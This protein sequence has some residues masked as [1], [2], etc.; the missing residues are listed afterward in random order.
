M[1][2]LSIL[3]LLGG[4][5]VCAASSRFEVTD[6]GARADGKTNDTAAIQ[7]A[8]DACSR[9]GGGTVFLAPGNYLSGT[10]VLK[11]DVALHLEPGATIW[12]S[13][14]MSDFNPRHLI[15]AHGAENIAIEGGGTIN[16]NG[17]AF[18]YPDFRPHEHRP[19]PYIELQECRNV[20]IRD[21][22][23]RNTPGWAIHP[24]NCDGVWIRGI[25]IVSPMQGPNTDGIDPDSSRNV[26]ISDSYIETGDDC[27]VLKTTGR[28]GLPAR[29]C[30]NVAVTNCV[31]VSDDTA[32]KLGTES[33]GDFRHIS[34]SGCVIRGT[35]V[36]LG[37][38]AKDGGTFEAVTFSGI[39][40]ETYPT[41]P[42]KIEYPI[43]VDLEK[44]KPE[45]K[46]S[47]VRDISFNDLV[48]HTRG[49][50]LVGG[51]P[52]HPLE[53]ISFRNIFMR[54]A[55]FV[56]VEGVRKTR[57][58]ANVLATGR[59]TDYAEV[60]AA[61]IFANVRNLELQGVRVAWDSADA[62]P[63][64]HAIYAAH[65]DGLRIS[66]FTGRQAVPGGKLAAIGLDS[67]RN[68]LVT[69]S[70]AADGAGVFL[71]TRETSREQIVLEGNSLAKV[72]SQVEQGAIHIHMQ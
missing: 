17:E 58:S 40:M 47:L 56:P 39:I 60:P 63:E 50:A 38:Y 62:A 54:V 18:W 16:G 70:R 35:R 48:I 3:F 45:S 23:I 55:G 10:I 57:G 1:K 53:N 14:Q 64:R 8:I 68:V 29:A 49:R 51:M 46:P 72:R 6:Y 5:P 2:H 32:I 21:V 31:L 24:V 20:R 67:V 41:H 59:E 65:V 11:S 7:K 66:D 36:G 61:F 34:F 15:Y 26:F 37:I 12:G 33:F 42:D 22:H 27:I 9:N 30:E 28:T 25:S 44:R 71:G 43:F 52:D 4:L 13:R 19:S 69:G